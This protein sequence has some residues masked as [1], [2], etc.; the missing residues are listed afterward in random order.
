M[1]MFQRVWMDWKDEYLTKLRAESEKQEA[2]WR[3]GDMI[4][5]KLAVCSSAYL[6]EQLRIY[7]SMKA[8]QAAWGS[9]QANI[10]NNLLKSL[11]GRRTALPAKDR[12]EP[13]EKRDKR[14]GKERSDKRHGK[15]E[16]ARHD[17]AA[18]AVRHGSR[19]GRERS[20]HRERGRRNGGKDR[21]KGRTP[22]DSASRKFFKNTL[23][24][25]RSDSRRRG[26][27]SSSPRESSRSRRSGP[28]TAMPAV[29]AKTTAKMGRCYREY[30]HKKDKAEGGTN[31]YPKCVFGKGCRFC[32]N[33]QPDQDLLKKW[34]ENPPLTHEKLLDPPKLVAA[35]ARVKQG[36]QRQSKQSRSRSS[37]A[38]S[39]GR[40][41]S[42]RTSSASSVSSASGSTSRSSRSEGKHRRGQTNKGSPARKGNGGKS[43]DDRRPSPRSRRN[44]RRE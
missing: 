12:R 35:P 44:G 24:R 3:R 33:S 43:R 5:D 13:K 21:S 16:S 37:S 22:S 11:G 27:P 2:Q 4:E 8:G 28:P 39:N 14:D 23:S 31:K 40:Q 18:P 25:D 10:Q 42:R 17:T 7:V 36:G 9:H 32:H 1:T 34:E 26:K 20:R 15:S 19:D 29:G 6:I 38:S 30:M 41:S